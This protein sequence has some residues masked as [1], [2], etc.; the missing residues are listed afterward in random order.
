MS[1]DR[2]KEAYLRETVFELLKPLQSRVY[3]LVYNFVEHLADTKIGA[4]NKRV[5]V[6]G[7]YSCG[8]ELL[9]DEIAKHV[10]RLGFASITGKGYY[11][12]GDTSTIHPIEEIFP[13]SIRT[14][15]LPS[16]YHYRVIARIVSKAIMLVNVV[17]SQVEELVVSTEYGIPVLGLLVHDQI[18]RSERDCS[19]L[20]VKENS[21]WCVVPS[22]NL[23]PASFPHR[24]FCPFVDSANLPYMVLNTLLQER[25]Y[26]AAIRDKQSIQT[27]LNRF[28]LSDQRRKKR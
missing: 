22:P 26:L 8:Y 1:I 23:C 21:A 28:L 18:T 13:P 27:V 5:G 20:S 3:D 17:R 11:L 10:S 4:R 16:F 19:F 15:L 12:P 2:D 14:D 24:P 25:N 9:L 7:P 6:F